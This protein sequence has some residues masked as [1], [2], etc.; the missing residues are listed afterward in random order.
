MEF[1][2]VL[3]C[4]CQMHDGNSQFCKADDTEMSLQCR[5]EELAVLWL[6]TLVCLGF[7]SG[8][9]FLLLVHSHDVE[10]HQPLTTMLFASFF[11]M[12]V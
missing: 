12:P 2:D 7:L 5:K 9:V 6:A 8:I 11:H 10:L 3:S 4:I 1:L